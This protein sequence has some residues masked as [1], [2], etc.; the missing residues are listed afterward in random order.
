M[1][2]CA[3]VKVKNCRLS[4]HRVKGKYS[5]RWWLAVLQMNSISTGLT[6]LQP[7]K[8]HTTYFLESMRKLRN[9]P[10][11]HFL[12]NSLHCTLLTIDHQLHI[13][14]QILDLY[15]VLYEMYEKQ[16]LYSTVL[17]NLYKLEILVRGASVSFY[18]TVFGMRLIIVVMCAELLIRLMLQFSKQLSKPWELLFML[19]KFHYCTD[20][21]F[22]RVNF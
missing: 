8:W 12:I 20:I 7:Q 1:S 21:T 15:F 19:C 22:V 6:E 5:I 13:H 17:Q 14:V 11:S 10:Y 4:A 18:M 16:C 9:T 2:I 3:L